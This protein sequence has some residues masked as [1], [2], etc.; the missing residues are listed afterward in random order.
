MLKL[1][2]KQTL[3]LFLCGLL[4]RPLPAIAAPG[5]ALGSVTPRGIVNVDNVQVPGM[6]ALFSGDQV[7]TGTGSALIQYEEGAR[8][9]L[10][11]ESQA[12][13]SATRVELKKGQMSF[14]TKA[15]G[16]LFAAS[17]LRIEPVGNKSAANVTYVDH[18]ATVAVTEGSFRIVDPSG[19]QLASLRAG[20]ARL[21]EEVAASEPAPP[22]AAAPAAPPAAPQ[23]GG[24]GN[25]AWLLALGVGIVGTSL[26]IA[27]LLRASDADDRADE[28]LDAANATR[29]EIDA[30][31]AQAAALSAQ[32]S[33][34]Q[35]QLASAQATSSQQ[36]AQIAELNT[37]LEAAQAALSQ[38]QANLSSQT[39]LIQNLQNEII[40]LQQEIENI[41]SNVTP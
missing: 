31:R 21:F 29:S 34:L 16:P 11:L 10:G 38:A 36:A 33:A 8:V 20:E 1:R 25:R 19:E 37:R 35:A 4:M 15:G 23:I 32:I 14:S 2:M 17:T 13:F 9:V 7:R 12:S 18:K 24:G 26:G 39:Q 27:A 30:A 5:A 22:A 6:S 41:T 3:A 28:A 40:L